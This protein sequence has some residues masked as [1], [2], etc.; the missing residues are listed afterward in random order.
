MESTHTVKHPNYLGVAIALGIMTI[1]EV[2]VAQAL[3]GSGIKIPLLIVLS[4]GKGALV[5]LYYMHLRFDSRVFSLFFLF[6]LFL[7]A[8][9]FVL[10]LLLLMP[11]I[12]PAA[13]R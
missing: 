3:T 8:V 1:A 11:S 9:P 10:V 5:A 13:S 4:A 7:L 12:A 2:I 6:A